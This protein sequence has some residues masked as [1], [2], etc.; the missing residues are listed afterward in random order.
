MSSEHPNSAHGDESH[1]VHH[2]VNFESRDI[3]TG[4]ILL[5]LAY[6]GIA[7]IVTFAATVLILRFTTLRAER[8]ESSMPPSH[9]GVGPT[10]PPEPRLQGVPGH[11]ND[12][13]QDLRNKIAADEKANQSYGWVDKQAGL[14]KIPVEDAMKIIVSKGLP[15]IAAPATEKKK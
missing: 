13:Q 14:A 10:M 9:Q 6:L 11:V 3:N 5:S 8:S 1:P 12:P 15:A 7:V 4:S 2:D